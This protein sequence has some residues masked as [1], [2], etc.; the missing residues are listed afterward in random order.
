[1]PSSIWSIG[2]E[3]SDV[4]GSSFSHTIILSCYSTSPLAVYYDFKFSVFMGF[5]SVQ[6][7]VYIH[8]NLFLVPFLGFSSFC[9]LFVLPYSG[10]LIFV[11]SYC[12]SLEVCLFLVTDRK[13]LN[14]NGRM[15][16]GTERN[17]Y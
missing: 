13:G 11:L 7:S 5:L 14:L 4:F 12:Y 8:L 3:L 6:M 9:F 16:E 1:M 17:R 2:N 10:V 15:W